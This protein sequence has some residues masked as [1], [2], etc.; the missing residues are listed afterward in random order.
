MFRD[1]FLKNREQNL[2]CLGYLCIDVIGSAQLYHLLKIH[3]LPPSIGT[4]LEN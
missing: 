4:S 2:G 1:I 3:N